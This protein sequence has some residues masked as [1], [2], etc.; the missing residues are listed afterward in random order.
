[1][2][3]TVRVLLG[4]LAAHVC[5]DAFIYSRFISGLKR[6]ENP[7]SRVAATA[8][9]CLFHAGFV[10]LFVWGL[11]LGLRAAASLYIF[12]VHFVIDT[13]RVFGE[14]K[15]FR[16]EG[17][18]ILSKKDMLRF[19]AGRAREPVNAFFRQNLRTWVGM[20]LVDQGLH[21]ATLLVFAFGIA[22]RLQ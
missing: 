7:A 9:H 8:L 11:P 10:F 15:I 21:A 1:M 22:P 4:L 13:A 20:N 12:C 19:L 3:E 6:S 18:V 14:R 17:M 16:P 2:P 5:G